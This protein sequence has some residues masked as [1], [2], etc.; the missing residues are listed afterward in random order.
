[1]PNINQHFKVLRKC[2]TKHDCLIYEMLYIRELSPFLNVQSLSNENNLLRRS[3][4]RF[5]VLKLQYYISFICTEVITVKCK[6]SL[7][8]FNHSENIVQISIEL[9]PQNMLFIFQQFMKFS[10]KLIYSNMYGK[11]RTLRTL[12]C[13]LLKRVISKFMKSEWFFFFNSFTVKCTIYDP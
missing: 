1:M 9:L 3:I 13:L 5:S 4:I 6:E 10:W 8:H 7:N 12:S 2:K 11:I